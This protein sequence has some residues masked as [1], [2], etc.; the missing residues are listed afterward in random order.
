MNNT[1]KNAHSKQQTFCF[2]LSATLIPFSRPKV[3]GF[4]F[5]QQERL[6]VMLHDVNGY[7]VLITGTKSPDRIYLQ[8]STLS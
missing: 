3:G 7:F 2:A 4:F 1:T 5:F 8:L 6:Q